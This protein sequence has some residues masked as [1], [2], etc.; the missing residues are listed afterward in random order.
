MALCEYCGNNGIVTKAT[1]RVTYM[2]SEAADG[3]D[4]DHDAQVSM[5]V[6]KDCADNGCPSTAKREK[7]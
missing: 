1:L 6:C 2:A 7:L 3:V 5:A 4:P